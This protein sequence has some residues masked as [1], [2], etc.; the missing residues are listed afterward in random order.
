MSMGLSYECIHSSMKA[1]TQFLMHNIDE[2]LELCIRFSINGNYHGRNA[3]M[4]DERRLDWVAVDVKKRGSRFFGSYPSIRFTFRVACRNFKCVFTK[5]QGLANVADI[6]LRYGQV[7]H[8]RGTQR[9]QKTRVKIPFNLLNPC[10]VDHVRA[11]DAKIVQQIGVVQVFATIGELYSCRPWCEA[12]CA[13][14]S[15]QSRQYRLPGQDA[16]HHLVAQQQS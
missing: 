5:S 11:M 12:R 9:N 6:A 1:N 8:Q 13:F 3:I 14:R 7:F 16:R 10:D 4:V 2:L 15:F